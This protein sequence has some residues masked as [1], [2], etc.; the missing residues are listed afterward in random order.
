MK[1]YLSSYKLGNQENVEILKSLIAP[2]NKKCAY[3][4]NA[5][6][7]ATDLDRK[8]KSIQNDIMDLKSVGLEVEILDLKD[9]FGKKSELEAKLEEFDVIWSRGGNVFNLRQAYSLSGFDEILL[10]YHKSKKDKVYGGY[11]A[12]VCVLCPTLKGYAIVDDPN[13][14]PYGEQFE[15]IWEGLGI[16]DYVV[17]PHY[18][19]DHPESEMIEKEIEKLIELKIYYVALRDGEVI[20]N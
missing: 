7:F 12:G 13:S 14:K 2:T 17:E 10:G 4:P 19:S 20:I 5:L 1:Y 11:S 6:D 16:L 9:Y 15:T 8:A 3:I 18:Q